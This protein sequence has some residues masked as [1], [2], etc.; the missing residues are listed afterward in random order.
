MGQLLQIGFAKTEPLA[1]VIIWDM[2]YNGLLQVAILDDVPVAGVSGPWPDGNFA[3]TWWT[4]LDTDAMPALEFHT[5]MAAARKRVE[6]ASCY[7][8]KAA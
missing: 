4:S 1:P 7:R 3:L 5:S 6:E 8:A 2:R